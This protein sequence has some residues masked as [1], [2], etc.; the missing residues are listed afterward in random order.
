MKKTIIALLASIVLIFISNSFYIS[1]NKINGNA[2]QD[3]LLQ[4]NINEIKKVGTQNP[5]GQA[6]ACYAMAYCRTILD[7]YAHS[8]TEYD[9]NN[10]SLGE[11]NAFCMWKNGNYNK[12]YSYSELNLYQNAYDSINAGRPFIVHVYNFQKNYANEHWIAIVGYTAGSNYNNLNENNFFIIDPASSVTLQYPISMGATVWRLLDENGYQ[13][14]Y[15]N[16]GNALKYYN[17]VPQNITIKSNN[18]VTMVGNTLDFEYTIENAELK[19][20]GID[21][22][23]KRY[24]SIPVTN[25]SGKISYNFSEAGTYCIITEGSNPKGYACCDGI[26]ITVVESTLPQNI[27]ITA[28]KTNVM[29]GEPVIFEYSINYAFDAAGVAIDKDRKRYASLEVSNTSGKIQYSFDTPG[30]YCVITEGRNSEG[31]ACCDGVWI[32][33]V[34]PTLPQNISISASKTNV[35]VGEP[36]IFEYSI[37]YAFDAAGVAIDKNRK[38]YESLVVN[39]TSGKIQYSFD[40]PGTYCVITE[41]RNSEGYA[42]CD[43]VWITVIGNGDCNDDGKFNISDVVVF[44]KWLL[45]E[46]NNELKKW[47]NADLN[48]DSMLDSFDLLLMKKELING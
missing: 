35:M 22:N 15:T 14:C 39:N 33:V 8:W 10:G 46:A 32:T 29:I 23:G 26:W 44:Q 13:Y 5:D 27:S 3:I 38:R 7:G 37:D 41:G 25:T 28:S 18:L 2:A 17:D 20:I 24:D 40:T 12:G 43:G 19:G 48:N 36:I 11:N 31:Y 4:I 1:K 6:C 45:K 34:E 30:T 16:S 21:K 9:A 47:Q 42:C